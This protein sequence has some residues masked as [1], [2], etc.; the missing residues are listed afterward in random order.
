MRRGYV[1]K[2]GGVRAIAARRQ[3]TQGTLA[4]LRYVLT[5]SAGAQPVP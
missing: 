4:S 3:W 5:V 1:V 2:L